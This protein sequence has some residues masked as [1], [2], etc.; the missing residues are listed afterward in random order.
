MGRTGSDCAAD[1]EPPAV[2]RLYDW[3][4]ALAAAVAANAASYKGFSDW[5]VPNKNELESI[6]KLDT[7]TSGQP[8]IDAAAFPNTPISGVDGGG[9]VWSST[10]HAPRPSVAWYVDFVIGLT[11]ASGKSGP[12]YARLVRSGQSSAS[13]D[14]LLSLIH[15]SSRFAIAPVIPAKAGIQCTLHR[16]GFPP[17]R[18]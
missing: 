16:A 15:I 4:G 17:S 3:P 13:F 8:S 2:P 9:G 7:W 11:F 1:T 10:T 6:T 12:H 18:V 14:L 5:R